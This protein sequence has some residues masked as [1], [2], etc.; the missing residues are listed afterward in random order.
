LRA[1]RSRRAKERREKRERRVVVLR[2]WVGE[3]RGRGPVDSE[4]GVK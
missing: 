4:A 1:R 2:I 3:E